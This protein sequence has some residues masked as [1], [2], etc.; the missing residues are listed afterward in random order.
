MDKIDRELF[1]ALRRDGYASTEGIRKTEHGFSI[2]F[3]LDD[4][5]DLLDVKITELHK[6]SI[7]GKVYRFGY[8]FKSD[9]ASSDRSQLIKW[10]K[11]L[12][13]DKPTPQ[14]LYQLI[15]AP[16]A[17]FD[18]EYNLASFDCVVYP[19]SLRSELVQNIVKVANRALQHDI[20]RPTYRL[21]K[22]L[23]QD[24]EFDWDMFDSTF[25][26]DKGSNRY[27]QMRQTIEKMMSALKQKTYFSIAESVKPK[28]REY[29][30][31][32][33]TVESE[34]E[35][36]ALAGLQSGKILIIDDINTTGAT[37]DEIL[38]VVQSINSDCQIFIFTLIG[39]ESE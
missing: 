4:A 22:Q 28:Y 14:E 5:F 25:G 38:R 1:S 12:L 17:L 23:P 10:I 21:V 27:N 9:V 2:D 11:G 34:E 26:E 24:V 15:S 36:K 29:I 18:K 33:L 20:S 16:L 3:T 39:K 13:P 6:S 31:N 30:K 32:Y 35:K 37:I 8:E 19:D 7:Q